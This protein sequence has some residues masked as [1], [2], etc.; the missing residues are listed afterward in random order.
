MGWN[1][2]PIGSP[3]EQRLISRKKPCSSERQLIAKFPTSVETADRNAPHPGVFSEDGH[4]RV[5]NDYAEWARRPAVGADAAGAAGGEGGSDDGRT[6]TPRERRSDVEGGSFR[7]ERTQFHDRLRELTAGLG[8]ENSRS[9]YDD[10]V[11][12]AQR[13]C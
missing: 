6:E 1:E 11:S 9:I 7:N 8:A 5:S 10:L 3:C 4:G 12:A 13:G 2:I